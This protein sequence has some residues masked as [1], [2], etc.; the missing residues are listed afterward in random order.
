MNRTLTPR[1][2]LGDSNSINDS[3]SYDSLLQRN[4]P[5]STYIGHV[6]VQNTPVWNKHKIHF[7]G[8]HWRWFESSVTQVI[9]WWLLTLTWKIF[10]TSQESRITTMD[11]SNPF[12]PYY[13]ANG[14]K[15]RFAVHVHAPVSQIIHQPSPE[16]IERKKRGFVKFLLVTKILPHLHLHPLR[17]AMPSATLE[18]WQWRADAV[19]GCH[20]IAS[21]SQRW[22]RFHTGTFSCNIVEEIFS[23]P[24]IHKCLKRRIPPQLSS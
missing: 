21:R 4:V 18:F 11:S 19:P 6:Q 20:S 24:K 1:A 2:V 8:L 15:N 10:L 12:V 22:E 3:W 14:H 7:I 5:Y 16:K 13:S 17:H 23:L 9:S